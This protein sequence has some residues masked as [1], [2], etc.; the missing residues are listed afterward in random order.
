MADIVVKIPIELTQRMIT[1]MGV[2]KDEARA[3]ELAIELR[4]IVHECVERRIAEYKSLS[5]ITHDIAGFTLA[6]WRQALVSSQATREFFLDTPD[7]QDAAWISVEICDYG[8]LFDRWVR[9][10]DLVNGGNLAAAM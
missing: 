9:V 3:L 2:I 7:S 10:G 6:V 1:W 5:P 8:D 4:E